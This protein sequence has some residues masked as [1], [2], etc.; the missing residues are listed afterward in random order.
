[1]YETE[2]AM[3]LESFPNLGF[4]QAT[5]DN[6]LHVSLSVLPGSGP[7]LFVSHTF[8][9]YRPTLMQNMTVLLRKMAYLD[10]QVQHL[11]TS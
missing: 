2:M 9:L 6:F 11:D 7:K 1:M 4:V 10:T 5:Q 3:L 8:P